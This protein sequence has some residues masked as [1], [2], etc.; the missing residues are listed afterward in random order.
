MDQKMRLFKDWVR[1]AAALSFLAARAY[2][3]RAAFRIFVARMGSTAS[4]M[5]THR[6]RF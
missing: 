4:N 3:L 1:R 5:I 2:P 6:R